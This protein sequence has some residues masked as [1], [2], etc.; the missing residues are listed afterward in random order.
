[1]IAP[2]RPAARPPVNTLVKPAVVTFPKTLLNVKTVA[3][4]QALIQF[5]VLVVIR[6][7]V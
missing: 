1:M 3:A 4:A 2:T 7:R 5:M 6:T